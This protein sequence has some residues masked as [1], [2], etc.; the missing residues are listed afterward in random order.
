MTIL[1]REELMA[2]TQLALTILPPLHERPFPVLEANLSGPPMYQLQ[3]HR[4][5]CL[6]APPARDRGWDQNSK[7]ARSNFLFP[8]VEP[9]MSGHIKFSPT[10]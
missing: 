9:P 6:D 8:N 7:E 4:S 1:Q 2:H 10:T 5:S 3:G